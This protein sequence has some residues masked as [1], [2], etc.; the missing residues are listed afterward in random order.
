LFGIPIQGVAGVFDPVKKDFFEV[1]FITRS[2]PN[3][4]PE[5]SRSFTAGIVYTPKFGTGLTLTIDLY[6]IES[7][8]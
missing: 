4:Q 3:L 2:N 5:D 8:G 6:D 1:P 7:P